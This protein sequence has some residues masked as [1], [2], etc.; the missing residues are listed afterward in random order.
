VPVF[1]ELVRL[2]EQ[3]APDLGAAAIAVDHRLVG[4]HGPNLL[5]WAEVTITSA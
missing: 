5:V 2:P 1:E 3:L 4:V